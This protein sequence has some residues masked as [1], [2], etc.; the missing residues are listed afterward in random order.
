MILLESLIHHQISK[1]ATIIYAHFANSTV[2]LG[3]PIIKGFMIEGPIVMIY[4]G[5]I[6]YFEMVNILFIYRK[7]CKYTL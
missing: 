7:H 5:P 1:I 4:K 6:F 2:L 3:I